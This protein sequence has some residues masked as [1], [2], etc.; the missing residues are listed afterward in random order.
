MRSI[1]ISATMLLIV[2]LTSTQ[3]GLLAE[4]LV[5]NALLIAFDG[6]LAPFRPVADDYGI[7]LLVYDKATGRS[8]PLQV[9]ART[10]T[11][12]KSGGWIEAI[13]SIS[14]CVRLP[15]VKKV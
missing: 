9:K 12:K 8:L 2:S 15:F 10:K 3:V 11:L 13:W 5:T 4:N 14:R 1:F 7:D 6:R